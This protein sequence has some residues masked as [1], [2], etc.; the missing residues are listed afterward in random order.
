MF[1][2]DVVEQCTS[3]RYGREN[4]A[5]SDQKDR[6]VRTS[7]TSRSKS[8]DAKGESPTSEEGRRRTAIT[9]G[10]AALPQCKECATSLL[11]NSQP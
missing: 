1:Q 6:D 4:D 7:E 8:D 11:T 5:P 10:N 3:W 2:L 9:G